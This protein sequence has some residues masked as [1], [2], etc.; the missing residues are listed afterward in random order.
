[1]VANLLRLRNNTSLTSPKVAA[2]A[3]KTQI[4][5]NQAL[6]NLLIAKGVFTREEFMEQI[7]VVKHELETAV[8]SN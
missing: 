7:R 3:L 8:K 1:M 2:D 6:V 4:V 5:V